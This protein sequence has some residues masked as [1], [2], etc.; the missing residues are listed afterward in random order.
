MTST[1]STEI[2]VVGVYCESGLDLETGEVLEGVTLLA[3][4]LIFRG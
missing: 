2:E 4:S 3:G 1:G